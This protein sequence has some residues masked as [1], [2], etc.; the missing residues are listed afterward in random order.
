MIDWDF[1]DKQE[2][3]DYVN[4]YV[5]VDK[6]GNVIE[7]SGVT[8][9]TGVDIGQMSENDLYKLLWEQ[10]GELTRDEVG[11]LYEKLVPYTNKTRDEALEYLKGRSLTIN[12]REAKFLSRAAKAKTLRELWA[13]WNTHSDVEFGDLPEGV[14]TVLV[15][16]AYNLGSNLPKYYPNTW[17]VFIDGA[18]KDDWDI[19]IDWLS[20]FPAKSAAL[21]ARRKRE[22][23]YLVSSLALNK[24]V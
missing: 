1:L 22:A 23:E 13:H 24:I 9:A 6:H 14:R 21:K 7:R 18:K 4:G 20:D 5:P 8:I 11:A 10:P 3:V 16:L 12:R 2:G 15:S 17:K 19:A